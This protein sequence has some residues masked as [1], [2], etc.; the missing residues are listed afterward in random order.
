MP[1]RVKTPLRR[2]LSQQS[3]PLADPNKSAERLVYL[4]T[5]MGG[6]ELYPNARLALRHYRERETDHINSLLK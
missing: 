2:G 5:R 3:V 6:R 1:P 4:G